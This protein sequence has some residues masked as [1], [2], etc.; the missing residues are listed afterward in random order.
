[1]RFD[2]RVT[3]P[4][5]LLSSLTSAFSQ[6]TD[7]DIQSQGSKSRSFN[8]PDLP[9][10]PAR[11]ALDGTKLSTY[12][13]MMPESL[14]PVRAVQGSS[15]PRGGFRAATRSSFDGSAY[16]LVAL[17]SLIAEGENTHPALGKG[18]P[19]FWGYSW[20]GFVDRTDGNYWVMF[21]L[22]A[23][24]HEDERFHMMQHG[25]KFYRLVYAASRVLI[26][27]DGNG[28]RTVNAAELLGRGASQ[29]I[30]LTYYPRSDRSAQA[31][32][33]KYGNTLLR[34]AAMNVFREFRA[35]IETRILHH[36]L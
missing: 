17:T 2:L 18:V 9:D 15:A 4:L 21:A 33:E 29:G 31:F 36:R 20:R 24:L 8:S 14:L 6:T 34:D 12:V 28:R 27:R 19:G 11:P 1:M 25:R 30:S 13:P 3:V 5:L 26:A 23:V 16:L 10:A 7:H 35:D 32:A 22:P